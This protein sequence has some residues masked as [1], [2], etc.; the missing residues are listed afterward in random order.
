M[1]SYVLFDYIEKKNDSVIFFL[2][3]LKADLNLPVTV[4][5]GYLRMLNRI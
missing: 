2:F 1:L 5:V 3:A 4:S